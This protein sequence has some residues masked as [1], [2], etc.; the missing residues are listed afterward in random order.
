MVIRSIGE[1]P[2][3]GEASLPTS[4]PAVLPEMPFT[5]CLTL[6]KSLYIFEPQC[7]HLE[8]G[9]NNGSYRTLTGRRSGCTEIIY[10]KPYRSVLVYIW[11]M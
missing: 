2:R 10:V 4:I 8:H 9:A 7:P 6:D 11:K 5:G 1:G 3:R